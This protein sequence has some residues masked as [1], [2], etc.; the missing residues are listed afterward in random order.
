MLNRYLS[1]L[2]LIVF[3][4]VF[5]TSTFA[6]EKT[7][8]CIHGFLR[9]K[10]NMVRIAHKFKTKD[11]QVVNWEYHSRKKTIEEHSNDLVEMLNELMIK[12]PN[13]RIYFVTHSMGAL[14]LCGAFNHAKFPKEAFL[15]KIVLLA[16]PMQGSVMARRL[17]P[18]KI[19]RSIFGS[20]AGKELMTT[21]KD[22]FARLG[23]F[24]QNVPTMVIAGTGGY[25][26]FIQ[27]KNDGKVGVEETRLTI[28]HIHRLVPHGHFWLSYSTKAL[29]LIEDF[30]EQ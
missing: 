25:N 27:G 9:S 22:G 15:G 13:S 7:V 4:V 26:P 6:G 30:F 21:R 19:F 12:H 17:Y 24:P 2:L 8:V 11:W 3:S 28:P 29:H 5:H 18:Y 16:P 1:K 14:V 10:W 20:Y 23:E